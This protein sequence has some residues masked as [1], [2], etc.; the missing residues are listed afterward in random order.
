MLPGET[1]LSGCTT[2]SKEDFEVLRSA[3]GWYIGTLDQGM[4]NT[5]E[6]GY[7]ATMEEAAIAL[8]DFKKTGNL[9]KQRY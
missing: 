1:V 4:P 2:A 8:E 3:A 9:R 7:F 6:T 5:R